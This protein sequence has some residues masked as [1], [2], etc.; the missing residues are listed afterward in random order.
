MRV[1]LV[2]ITVGIFLIWTGALL[3][4]TQLVFAGVV[5]LYTAQITYLVRK[6][7]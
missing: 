2:F 7:E 3:K 6:E 1:V 4:L 5:L